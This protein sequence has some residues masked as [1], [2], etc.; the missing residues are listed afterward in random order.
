MPQVNTSDGAKLQ[1]FISQ[2][3]YQLSLEL[4]SSQTRHQIITWH[5][6]YLFLC[7]YGVPQKTS[8]SF[9]LVEF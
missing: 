3:V 6:M 7:A 1:Q 9:A 4:L 5:F 2:N 8:Q